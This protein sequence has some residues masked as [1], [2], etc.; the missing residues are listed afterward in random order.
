MAV[1][2]SLI[3]RSTNA[4]WFS[5]P[6]V[7]VYDLDKYAIFEFVTLHYSFIQR[8][9]FYSFN[10][11][12]Y[13]IQSSTWF[14]PFNI[15]LLIR[16]NMHCWESRNCVITTF[17]NLD[18]SSEKNRLIHNGISDRFGWVK[19]KANEILFCALAPGNRFSVYLLLTC[20]CD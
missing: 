1:I 6:I 9:I 15:Q 18:C 4:E 19:Y 12:L 3:G 7:W 17:L 2:A 16:L 10:T 11:R 13:N 20:Q 5:Y 14:Q 8:L